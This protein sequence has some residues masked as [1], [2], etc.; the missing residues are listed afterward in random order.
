M[1]R[2]TDLDGRARLKGGSMSRVFLATPAMST[3]RTA[4]LRRSRDGQQ[5]HRR[6]PSMRQA[7]EYLR[8]CLSDRH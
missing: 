3:T 5:L 7:I 4:A 1:L 2:D 8:M 6:R